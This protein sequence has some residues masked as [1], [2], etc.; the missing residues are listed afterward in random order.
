MSLLIAGMLQRLLAFH[1]QLTSMMDTKPMIFPAK[2][3]NVSFDVV[4]LWTGS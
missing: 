3:T 1:L 4:G 2:L